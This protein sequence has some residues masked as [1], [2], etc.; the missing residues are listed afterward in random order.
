MWKANFISRLV[1]IF[2]SVPIIN[3]V[4]AVNEGKYLVPF[5]YK[6]NSNNIDLISTVSNH[7]KNQLKINKMKK[8]TVKVFDN[9]LDPK[10]YNF[11][12]NE[13]KK[14]KSEYKLLFIG[15]LVSDKNIFNLLKAFVVVAQNFKNM[16]LHIVG[17]GSLCRALELEILEE[18]MQDRVFM[19][20]S[21][22]PKEHIL[23][24]D[25]VVLPSKHEA[26]GLVL[27]EAAV[28]GVDIICSQSVPTNELFKDN[29][30]SFDPDS[31][32]DIAK[33]IR[34]FYLEPTSKNILNDRANYVL[35]RYSDKSV[36]KLWYDEY[37]DLI[38]SK[39]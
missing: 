35:K 20:G 25:L 16:T 8:N 21:V 26:F 27:L 1:S 32:N 30:H 2:S 22:S 15:R 11:K 6:I 33:A 4:H 29:I 10:F 12:N 23:S 17:D 28:C 38:G 9:I 31:V 36:C 39:I 24:A 19:H 3:T 34:N 14:I 13:R 18:N 37:C 7:A 5:L